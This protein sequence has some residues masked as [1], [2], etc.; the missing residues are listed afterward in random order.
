LLSP[1]F[2]FFVGAAAS[3]VSTNTSRVSYSR[4]E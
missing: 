2:S 3:G 1:F 4:R